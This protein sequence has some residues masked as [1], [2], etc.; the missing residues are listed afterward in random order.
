VKVV[1]VYPNPRKVTP[2][3]V[4]AGR[5]PDTVLLGANHLPSLGIESSIHVPRL[6]RTE[7]RGGLRHRLTWNLRELPLPWELGDADAVCTSLANIFPLTARLRGRPRVVLLNFGIL[8]LWSRSSPLRRR[9]LRTSL[10]AADA[11]VCLASAHR[12]RLVEEVGLNPQRTVVAEFGVD[13]SFYRATP[14]PEEGYVL[15]V[16]KDLA[17]DYGTFLDAVR[18]LD[19]RVVVVTKQELLAP[20][21]VPEN[22]EVHSKRL[23]WDELL[24][25]YAGARCVVLPL[26]ADGYRFGTE[27]SGLTALLEGMANGRPIVAARREAFD[28]YVEPG[29]S[30]LLVPPADAAA[31]RSEIER[32]L[33]DRELAARLAAQARATLD[34]RFTSR[35][36]AVRLAATLR[37][38]APAAT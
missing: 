8:T 37:G 10:G 38:T 11:V 13:G 21:D 34:D 28:D 9:L 18:G 27:A 35:H 24:R 36:L 12:R 1:Y 30:A 20:F 31:L 29:E 14:L 7:R 15:A 17:R 3:A 23:P 32:V 2:E 4:A 16:G 6:R 19:S 25:L 5:E 26:H 33:G 22:V